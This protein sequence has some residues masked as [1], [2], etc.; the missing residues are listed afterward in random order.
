MITFHSD[1]AGF[2]LKNRSGYKNWL[3]S[4]I[5]KEGL[6]LGEI[7]YIF[8]TDSSLLEINEE[9]LDHHDYTDV[10]TF[11]LSEITNIIRG[12]IYISVDRVKE[13][14]EINRVSFNRELS[15]VLV[16]GVL[17]LV[18]F[19]DHTIQEKKI[20]RYKEDYYLDLLVNYVPREI[21]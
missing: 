4:V 3:K 6:T 9:F 21:L 8:C 10:I 13:N 18:G 20:M 7:N 17:H 5:V 1:Y 14:S 15:R 12:E 11:S 16:H 2:E 19:N